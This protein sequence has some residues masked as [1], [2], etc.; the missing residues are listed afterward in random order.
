MSGSAPTLAAVARGAPRPARTLA[1]EAANRFYHLAK[2]NGRQGRLREGVKAMKQAA[3]VM[4]TAHGLAVTWRKVGHRPTQ[5]EYASD[6]GVDVRTAERD[7]A[8][9]RQVFCNVPVFEGNELDIYTVAERLVLDYGDRLARDEP[10][11]GLSVPLDAF[12]LS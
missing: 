1:E 4:A 6:W 10:Q 8:L 5:A 2:L 11:A 3:D 12:A 7:F 9:W